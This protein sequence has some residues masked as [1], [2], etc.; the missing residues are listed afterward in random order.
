MKSII[1][2]E[3]LLESSPA[4]HGA[5]GLKFDCNMEQIKSI[6]GPAP[7]GA[8]GLKYAL[9]IVGAPVYQSRPARGGWIEICFRW[10]ISVV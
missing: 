6:L 2:V 7:H 3:P 8:G 9:G 4:P 1:T 10:G 5:G